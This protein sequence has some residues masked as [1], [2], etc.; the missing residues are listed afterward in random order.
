[1][2]ERRQTPD[3][4]Y[5][6]NIKREVVGRLL[7][8][9]LAIATSFLAL[10]S[11]QTSANQMLFFGGQWSYVG[12]V[13][14]GLLGILLFCDAVIND[15]MTPRF[16][17][18]WV[19]GHR[20]GLWMALGL[21]FVLFGYLVWTTPSLSAALGVYMFCFAGGAFLLAFVDA[22]TEKTESQCP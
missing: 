6:T 12:A 15:L 20:Q 7:V 16:L 2:T 4:R 3:F 22:A 21:L 13:L 9:E 17:F 8:A 5:G 14:I 19:K 1:M 11:A 10:F 18:Q